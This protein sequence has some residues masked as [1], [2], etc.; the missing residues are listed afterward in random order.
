MQITIRV[1]GHS[2]LKK[3]VKLHCDSF[4]A[5]EHIPVL[6]GTNYIKAN[7]QWLLNSNH[8]YVLI[9]ENEDEIAGLIAVSDI[10]FT[11]PMFIA[12]LPQML[13]GF[14]LKPWL[15]FNKNLWKRLTRKSE[16]NEQVAS[17]LKT[18]E[19]A[20][21]TIGAVSANYRGHGVFGSLVDATRSYSQA[22]GSK[23]IRAG[24]YKNNPSSR[25]VFIKENWQ[26]F[27]QLETKDTVFYVTCFDEYFADKFG[28]QWTDVNYSKRLK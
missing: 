25:K 28:L 5:D 7:Y 4:K 12:C 2:D 8:S 9:A 3:L 1:A 24:V 20:Q 15:I 11:R 6:F 23:A 13:L 14:L 19:F 21:M 27:K 22:R 10:A 18:K 16:E 26:E 17:I